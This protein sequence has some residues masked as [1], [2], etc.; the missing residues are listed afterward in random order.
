LEP[1]AWSVGIGGQARCGYPLVLSVFEFHH[2]ISFNFLDYASSR[3]YFLPPFSR[4]CFVLHVV[5]LYW[6]TVAVG[7]ACNKKRWVNSPPTQIFRSRI[8]RFDL[9][10]FRHL[11]LVSRVS[12]PSRTIHGIMEPFWDVPEPCLESSSLFDLI[13]N[14]YSVDVKLLSV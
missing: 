6:C 7:S 12:D 4:F 9:I 5:I 2:H 1:A 13:L 3:F 8:D 14:S 10:L 11:Y